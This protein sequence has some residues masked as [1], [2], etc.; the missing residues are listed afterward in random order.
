MAGIDEAVAAIERG[1]MVVI[2][3]DTVYGI[4][5]RPDAAAAIFDVKRR[6][7]EKALPVLGSDVVQLGGIAE[8]D[9]SA[10]AL[11]ETYWPGPLT[12]VVRRKEQFTADLGSNDPTTVAIRVPAH[13]VAQELLQRTGPLAVTSANVSGEPP[14]ATY[15]EACALAPELVCLD[16]G[17]CDGVP[18]TVLTLVGEARVLRQGGLDLTEWLSRRGS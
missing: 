2:P 5:A 4:G 6:P 10:R 17:T 7:R 15:E 18:S 9:D 11:A 14:A 12:I 8:L 3:T 16:G 13:P 1:A